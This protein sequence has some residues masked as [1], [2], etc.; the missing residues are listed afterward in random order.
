MSEPRLTY[1]EVDDNIILHYSQDV[2]KHLEAAKA[3]RRND[4]E[5]RTA[6]GKRA[7]FRHIMHVPNNIWLQVCAKLQI[8]F[9]ECFDP[10]HQPR[11]AA[12]LKSAEYKGFRVVN[13]VKI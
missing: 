5:Y 1:H 11:I 4:A 13:D 6:F 10:A 9:G 3:A 8:P 12:E 7:E 2:E